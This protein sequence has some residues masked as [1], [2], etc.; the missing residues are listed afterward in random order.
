MS[1]VS[2]RVSSW[3]PA[4]SPA[5]SLQSIP[6]S[7]A[8]SVSTPD[9]E[10]PSYF[11]PPAYRPPTPPRRH[12]PPLLPLHAPDCQCPECLQVIRLPRLID[13]V[14]TARSHRTAFLLLLELVLV[15]LRLRSL[16]PRASLS[17]A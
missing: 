3:I 9:S 2:Q 8:Q 5:A 15:L 17:P 1:S 13:Q 16:V 11:R 12:P 6:F 7:P 10:G 4:P 14:A